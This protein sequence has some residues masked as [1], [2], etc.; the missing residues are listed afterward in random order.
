MASTTFAQYSQ[1]NGATQEW[2]LSE[3]T[4]SGITTT[5][6]SASG[7]VEFAFSGISGLPFSGSQAATFS[8]TGTKST[9]K[10]NC[11]TACATND[12]YTQPGYSGTFSF[13]DT[14]LGTNLLSGTFATKTGSPL[15]TGAQVGST[16]GGHGGSFDASDDAGNLTQIVF[17][18]KYLTFKNVTSETASWSLSS[19]ETA[20]GAGFAVGAVTTGTAYPSGTFDAAATGTFSTTPAPTSA[21]PEPGTLVLIGG[22][23][24]GLGIARRRKIFQA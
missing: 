16:I 15:T 17:T 9:D 11:G 12:S 21:T 5:T 18:S 19:L 10:G 8:L 4:V 13:T 1:T 22:G 23:L 2:S 24:L 3:A 20:L 14:A 7:A 6:V